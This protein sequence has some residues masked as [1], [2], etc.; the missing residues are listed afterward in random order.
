MK[1]GFTLIEMLAIIVV[2]V[3]V[4]SVVIPQVNNSTKQRQNEEFKE[5]AKSI[6]NAAKLYVT[7]NYEIV[8]NKVPEYVTLRTLLINDYVPGPVKDPRT[9]ESFNEMALV[10]IYQ[11]EEDV[12]IYEFD[13][14]N[15]L[16]AVTRT[17]IISNN[18][19]NNKYARNGQ[20]ITLSVRFNKPITG[21]P[22][23]T[24]GGR[25]ATVTGT[26]T[27]RTATYTIPVAESTL[28]EGALA[29]SITN[30]KDNNEVLGEPHTS[31]TTGGNVIY[32]R[33]PPNF[34][35]FYIGGVSNPEFVTSRN[36]ILHI[37]GTG[38]SQMCI[39][40]TTSCS[41]WEP[42][43]TTKAYTLSSGDGIKTLYIWLRDNAGNQVGHYS[44]TVILS[45]TPPAITYFYIGGTDNPSH[46]NN[47]NTS[48]YILVPNATQ[49][50]ISTTTSCTAWEDY[51]TIKAYTLTTGD[52]TKTVNAWF[53]NIA[54]NT[55]SMVSDSILLDTTP[56]TCVSSGGSTTWTN[57]NRTITGTCS[58]TGSGCAGNVTRTYS[59]NT[60]TTTASPG[61]VCDNAGNCVTCPANRTV[62]I[63]KTAP[64]CVSSGGSTTWATTRTI[65]GTCSDTG[66]SGC[67]G[68][69][70]TTYTTTT[71]TTTAS[72]GQVCDNAGNCTTCAANQTV[73]VDKTAPTCVSS[74]GSTTW[75][76]GNRTL[77]GTCSDSHSGCT[78]NVTR[79]ISTNTNS[80]TQGPGQVCDNVGNCTTCP[81]N[82]TVRIDKSAPTCSSS[83]GSTTWT[84]GNRTLTGTCSDTGGSGCSGNV[85]RTIST[86]TNSTTQ[87]PGQVCDNAGNCVTC[88]TNQTVRIDKSAPTCSS[89]GGST[90]WTNGNRTLTG[91]CSDT[92]GSGCVGNVTRTIST[93][94]NSTTQGPGQVCDNAG[95]CVT[96][97]TN[98]TVRIDK[99]NP[100]CTSSGGSTTWTNGNRTITGTCSDTGGSGCAGNVT[101]TYST[102]T[103]TTTA[104]PG[105]VYD[106]AGNSVACP[107]NRTVRIDKT[108]PTISVTTP[109]SS[110]IRTDQT[111][112]YT[113]GDSGGSGV[114][115]ILYR[116]C[117]TCTVYTK[118][119]LGSP[120]IFSGERNRTTMQ[121]GIDDNAGNRTWSSTFT[122]RIDKTAP[123]IS[124]PF[125]SSTTTNI[126][127][128]G[129]FAA[130]SLS[131][132]SHVCS[133]YGTSVCTSSGSGLTTVSHSLFGQPYSIS[134]TRRSG[135]DRAGNLASNTSSVTCVISYQY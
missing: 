131:G 18:P 40:T 100:T 91:T 44:D 127:R 8:E 98:Q 82:Q 87:G 74:G 89:S 96:C 39:S 73:R 51:S 42:Y 1:K 13:N 35:H 9:K 20:L 50:C 93:N 88:P 36:T 119:S 110:W 114:K 116:D 106:N 21:Q 6:E 67:V 25:T 99:T 49:M 71:N 68:N 132:I 11:D 111:V 12:Y 80:T 77:T 84:N 121:L 23:I 7:E 126:V 32:D 85:T 102:N 78:G 66:G 107:A 83:G 115:A 19:L 134:I 2:L 75:T 43:S 122:T 118:A 41:S 128:V 117:S 70:T 108:A 22:T 130:D 27:T 72:P 104:S 79:T 112:N 56:P 17:S 58:D 61:D 124:S 92:G 60:N 24:I 5:L 129:S 94:T 64:T 57:G 45:T 31:I 90:T 29:I 135:T 54:G 26:G 86:N 33:T 95:N 133:T 63:D 65:T 109:T 101:R 30:Y 47:R 34:I 103:N 28:Q 48:L 52:G 113:Y 37:S 55:T 62:R 4:F 97:P 69:A 16:P 123:T 125:C 105:T 14:D 3:G 59:T 10:T 15:L 38:A 53:R 120:M 46:T 81:T 76:N